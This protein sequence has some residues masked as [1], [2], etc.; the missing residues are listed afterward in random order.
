MLKTHIEEHLVNLFERPVLG[1]GQIQVRP[2]SAKHGAAAEDKA[3]LGAEVR[4]AV[5]QQVR[6]AADNEQRAQ[7][8]DG[9]R[10][11]DRLGPHAV[12]RDLAQNRLR[13]G[14]PGRAVREDEGAGKGHQTPRRRDA[15]RPGH[16]HDREDQHRE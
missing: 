13:H 7:P 9:R 14:T 15:V 1:L 5:A 4:V 11:R 16:A 3:H 6:A 12:R 10:D 2:D 8:V